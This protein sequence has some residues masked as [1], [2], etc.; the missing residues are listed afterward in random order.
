M[1]YSHQAQDT[2]RQRRQKVCSDSNSLICSPVPRQC[3]IVHRGHRTADVTSFRARSPCSPTRAIHA[4]IPEVCILTNTRSLHSTHTRR[5][6]STYTRSLY[7]THTRCLHA[8]HTRHLHSTHTRNLHSTHTRRL[9]PHIP[10]ACIPRIP[11]LCTPRI[12]QCHGVVVKPRS[13]LRLCLQTAEENILLPWEQTCSHFTRGQRL[14]S[15]ENSEIPIRHNT[16]S[17]GDVK[18][19]PSYDNVL[20]WIR[21]I[22]RV[23]RALA[24][25]LSLLL[26]VETEEY[27][28]FTETV[29]MKVV[30]HPPD[31]MPFPEDEGIIVAPGFATSISI[32]KVMSVL[33][34]SVCV[35]VRARVCMWLCVCVCVPSMQYPC[36]CVGG[37]VCVCVCVCV[38]ARAHACV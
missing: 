34:H 9:H 11:D 8:T 7:S 32:R 1:L 16:L 36:V 33:W 3:L 25:G 31:A 21:I 27:L 22:R 19:C 35:C 24:T 13:T 6:H 23:L 15:E 10:V 5:L 17:D 28:D 30:V 18:V 12:P 4:H 37:C 29:G 20:Q 38:C 26:N 14:V 2:V